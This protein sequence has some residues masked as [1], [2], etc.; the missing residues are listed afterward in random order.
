MFSAVPFLSSRTGQTSVADI[1]SGGKC[2]CQCPSKALPPAVSKWG[3]QRESRKEERKVSELK[4][5]ELCYPL[6]YLTLFFFLLRIHRHISLFV[7][8]LHGDW[9]YLS[10]WKQVVFSEINEAPV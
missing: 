8:P 7:Q 5:F 6:A 3:M 10:S 4:G 9:Q 1:I 2:Y